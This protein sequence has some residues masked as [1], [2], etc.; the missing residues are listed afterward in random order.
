MNGVLNQRRWGAWMILA[1]VLFLGFL[2]VAALPAQAGEEA[3]PASAAAPGLRPPTPVSFGDS[4]ASSLFCPD[5]I[6]KQVGGTFIQ[7]CGLAKSS[8]FCTC[9]GDCIVSGVCTYSGWGGGPPNV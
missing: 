4:C 1:G 9:S 5:C 3:T 2:G 6:V 8:G 7:Y